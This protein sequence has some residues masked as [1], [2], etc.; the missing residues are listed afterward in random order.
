MQFWNF[1]SYHS[2]DEA[3]PE[4]PKALMF[5]LGVTG[6]DKPK[7]SSYRNKIDLTIKDGDIP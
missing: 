6:F 2:E 5:F 4:P 1:A 7:L 3:A